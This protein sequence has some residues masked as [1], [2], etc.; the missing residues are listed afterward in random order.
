LI[1]WRLS[2]Y[3]GLQGIGG[4]HV[5]GRWH[6]KGHPIVYAA[7]SASTAL[8]EILVHL[9]IDPDDIPDDFNLIE[10]N[11]PSGIA[12]AAEEVQAGDPILTDEHVSRKFGTSWLKERRSAILLVPSIIVSVETNV[13]INPE[14]PDACMI[15]V[16]GTTRFVFDKRLLRVPAN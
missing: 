10:I 6:D 16:I 9:D 5:A 4:L 11:I 7:A 3:T 14:H 2:R 1:V 8:L 15:E 12:L 13:L